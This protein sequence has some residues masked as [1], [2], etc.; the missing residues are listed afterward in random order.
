VAA[1]SGNRLLAYQP[2]KPI[3]R[4]GAIWTESALDFAGTIGGLQGPVTGVLQGGDALF[5][6]WIGAIYGALYRFLNLKVRE[7]LFCLEGLTREIDDPAVG[8]GLGRG[9]Q[10]TKGH[11]AA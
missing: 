9:A 7:A 3:D 4:N 6:A 8:R 5:E 2:G 11:E 10:T 1:H